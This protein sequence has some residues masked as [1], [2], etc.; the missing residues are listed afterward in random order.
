MGFSITLAEIRDLRYPLLHSPHRCAICTILDTGIPPT[1]S[2]EYSTPHGK[3]VHVADD[4]QKRKSVA[5]ME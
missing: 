2:S 3:A 4:L 5:V 1:V